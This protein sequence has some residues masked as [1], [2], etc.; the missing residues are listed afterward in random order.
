MYEPCL[1]GADDCPSCFP[2][3]ALRRYPL[4]SLSAEDCDILGDDWRAEQ[5]AEAEEAELTYQRMCEEDEDVNTDT[6]TDTHDPVTHGP[7]YRTTDTHDAL[8]AWHTDESQWIFTNKSI[9]AD[10]PTY[11]V[12]SAPAIFRDAP[13]GLG[14]RITSPEELLRHIKAA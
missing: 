8:G 5:A 3:R 9:F 6:D 10:E 12:G 14:W 2:G 13:M 4:G 11:L 7:A 1:C